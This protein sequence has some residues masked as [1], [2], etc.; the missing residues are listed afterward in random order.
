MYVVI[1]ERRRRRKKKTVFVPFRR[2]C[3]LPVARTSNFGHSF[4]ANEDDY[5][6]GPTPPIGPTVVG[7][8]IPG[9]LDIIGIFESH[10]E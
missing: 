5:F 4:G 8:G 9:R 10:R 2:R 7:F 1:S 3:Y 6:A